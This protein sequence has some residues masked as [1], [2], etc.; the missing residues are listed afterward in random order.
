MNLPDHRAAFRTLEDVARAVAACERCPRLRAHCREVA[1]A[2]KREFRDQLY[3]GRPVPG[4]GDHRARLLIVGLAPAA[5]GANRTG[6]MF[7]G[8]S[9]GDWLHEA[10]HHTGFANQPHSASCAEIALEDVTARAGLPLVVETMRALGVDELAQAELS[11]PRRRRGFTP[12]QKLE[13]LVTLLAAGGDRVEDIRILGEDQGLERLLGSPFPS[14][15]ALLDFLGQFHDPDCWANRPPQKKACVPPE[16]LGLRALEAINRKVV[17]R[18]AAP[19]TTRATIDHDGTIIAAHKRDARMAYEGTRGYQPLVAVWAEEQLIVADD[20]RDGNVAGGEDPLSSARR[21]MENLPPWVRERFF[22]GDSA[23]YYTPLL[24]YLVAEKIGFTISADMTRELRACCLAVPGEQWVELENRGSERVDIVVPHQR[25]HV[26]CAH[27]AQAAGAARAPARRP[28]QAAAFRV[29]HPARQADCPPESAIGTRL[30]RQGAVAGD[31][32][33]PRPPAGDAPG[34]PNQLDRP[35]TRRRTSSR[36][37][38]M[39]TPQGV[40]VKTSA[41]AWSRILR[42]ELWRA[43]VGLRVTWHGAKNG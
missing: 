33:G 27:R 43:R 18:G 1:E 10:L 29:V 32:R 2:R 8:D 36:C 30:G 20:F 3:W 35:L 39:A 21:A 42:A 25:A 16:S 38:L 24:K 7:T 34:A 23:A 5:H 17:A 13:A 12:A 31:R 19:A 4:F 6:R 22:R 11:Q 28:A 9:S 14:P 15:D 41:A 40:R 26:Q 37:A